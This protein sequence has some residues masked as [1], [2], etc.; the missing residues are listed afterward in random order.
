MLN[1]FQ[2]QTL[3]ALQAWAQQAPAIEQARKLALLTPV[4]DKIDHK[5]GPAPQRQLPAEQDPH[6]RWLHRQGLMP[7]LASL[8]CH[9]EDAAG[10]EVTPDAARETWK[11]IRQS[12][13]MRTLRMEAAGQT[14]ANALNA[15]GP[16]WAIMKGFALARTLYDHPYMRGS[17]DIDL[18]VRPKD[19]QAALQLLVAKGGTEVPSLKHSHEQCIV[20][21]GVHVDV[22]K[23]PMRFGRLRVNPAT[24]WVSRARKCPP[25]RFLAPHD[26]LV[27]SLIHPA[28]TEYLTERAVRMLDV[29]LQ[30]LRSEEQVDWSRVSFDIK[31]LGLAN[32]AY[33]TGIRINYL[34]PYEP[35]PIIPWSFLTDLGIGATRRRYW[36]YWMRRRPDQLYAVS[37]F[38]ARVLFSIWLNDSARDWGRAL[39]DK[40]ASARVLRE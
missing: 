39:S 40:H 19:H 27:L 30:V 9:Y 1:V 23:A 36:H 34:F 26:E 11:R 13:I 24:D 15:W 25:Y 5:A 12:S 16:P 20:I 4:A 35:D 31:R 28:V 10:D 8:L 3:Q 38:L 6:I 7:I 29:V 37:P 18:L 22:H 32:A 17:A 2:Q 21:Q 33:A 14:V